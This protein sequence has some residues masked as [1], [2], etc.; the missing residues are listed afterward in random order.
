MSVGFEQQLLTCR[1]NIAQVYTMLQEGPENWE[2]C[3]GIARSVMTSIDAIP[4]MT[5]TTRIDEQL[6]IIDGLQKLASQKPGNRDLSDIAH[7]CARQWLV[8]LEH[9]PQHIGTLQGLSFLL[10]HPKYLIYRSPQR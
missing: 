3:I 6:W 8:V 9:H 10:E 7:W 4:F 5:D 1:T 2:S